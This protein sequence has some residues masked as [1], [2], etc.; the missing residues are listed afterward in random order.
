MLAC[1]PRRGAA[2]YRIVGHADDVF[3]SVDIDRRF[4]MKFERAVHHS[5][6]AIEFLHG[7]LRRGSPMQHQT[8]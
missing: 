6:F 7:T 2:P 8:H 3:F 5:H 4:W 1:H